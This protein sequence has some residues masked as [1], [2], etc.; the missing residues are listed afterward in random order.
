MHI[1]NF[2][3]VDFVWKSERVGRFYSKL[4]VHLLTMVCLA[5][6]S[7][8]QK[9]HKSSINHSKRVCTLMSTKAWRFNFPMKIPMKFHR[10]YHNFIGKFIGSVNFIGNFIWN[11]TFPMKY[12]LPIYMRF[13][14]KV[15]IG[16]FLWRFLWKLHF[17]AFVYESFA[18]VRIK[19][20]G[21]TKFL[22]LT[23]GYLYEN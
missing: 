8:Y 6:D 9:G 1:L 20:Y 18:P 23:F 3:T 4:I 7:S 14:M 21:L 5:N 22:T 16:S 2:S 12:W 17:Q 11:K 10:K 19:K 13:H 15:F